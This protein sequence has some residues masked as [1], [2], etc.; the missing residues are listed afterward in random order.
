M[1]HEKERRRA[2]MGRK[3]VSHPI[4]RFK[5]TEV[6]KGIPVNGLFNPRSTRE[7]LRTSFEIRNLEAWLRCGVLWFGLKWQRQENK[8]KMLLGQVRQSEIPHLDLNGASKFPTEHKRLHGS[9][10]NPLSQWIIHKMLQGNS[11][12]SKSDI[13]DKGKA[14]DFTGSLSWIANI[15]IFIFEN[16]QTLPKT[17]CTNPVLSRTKDTFI[18]HRVRSRVWR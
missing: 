18:L 1:C 5:R 14:R 2:W 15:L 17:V 7:W 11:L 13:R 10:W 6:E 16:H 9:E 8:G 4:L 3:W 12:Q